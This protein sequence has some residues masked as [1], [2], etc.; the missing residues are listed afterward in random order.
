MCLEALESCG[1]RPAED[2]MKRS[3][4]ETSGGQ[5]ARLYPALNVL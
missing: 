4:T 2:I 5:T 3:L 1:L